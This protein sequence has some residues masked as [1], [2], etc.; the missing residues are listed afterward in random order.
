[1]TASSPAVPRFR[2]FRQLGVLFAREFEALFLSP[3]SYAVLTIGWLLN[4]FSFWLLLGQAQGNVT[5]AV[6][7]FFGSST[8]FWMVALLCCPAVHDAPLR[9]GAPHGDH[10]D[11]ADRS[12]GGAGGRAL[13]VL[14]RA[15][16][17]LEPVAAVAL[18]PGARQALR[19]I[20]EFGPLVTSYAGIVLSGSLF[21]AIGLF[22][23]SMTA[24]QILAAV[25]ATV[26]NLLLFLV[27]WLSQITGVE[28]VE[29]FFL[30]LWIFHHFED[31]FAQGSGRHRPRRVLPGDDDRVPVL[32]DARRGIA[33]V[34]MSPQTFTR[35]PPRRPSRPTS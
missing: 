17:L 15:L 19:A 29:R 2:F 6:R 5:V 1:M 25:F 13:E 14:R 35:G 24:N 23:S 7:A 22:A 32:V 9:R 20:P 4:G 16:L 8:L 33:E 21:T 18:L 11:A 10:R 12:G 28:E 34:A 30:E 3:I 26:L 31:S 27:P